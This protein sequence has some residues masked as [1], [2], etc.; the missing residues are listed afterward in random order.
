[1]PRPKN[2]DTLSHADYQ[3]AWRLRTGRTKSTGQVRGDTAAHKLTQRQ[4]DNLCRSIQE[5]GLTVTAV[6]A[7]RGVSETAI[8]KQLRK[9][10][11][12]PRS[13]GARQ[14]R[15]AEVRLTNP[16]HRK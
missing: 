15:A 16:G 8:R 4:W 1:M 9:R 11:V 14:S 12:Q 2:P 13:Y 6:A 7:K 3:R 5:S 10:G